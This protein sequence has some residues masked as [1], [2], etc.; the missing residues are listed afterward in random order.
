MLHVHRAAVVGRYTFTGQTSGRIQAEGKVASLCRYRGTR[1]IVMATC[2]TIVELLST[3]KNSHALFWHPHTRAPGK[4]QKH[5]TGVPQP[6]RRALG[7][8]GRRRERPS[9]QMRSMYRIVSLDGRSC[10]RTTQI[11]TTIEMKSRCGVD[12]IADLA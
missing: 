7:F 5:C 8:A 4:N 12:T 1:I 9:M 2:A 10:W 11:T 6:G 3:S